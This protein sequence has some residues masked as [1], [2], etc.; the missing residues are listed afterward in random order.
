MRND[1]FVCYRNGW[2]TSLDYYTSGHRV[3]PLYMILI[4]LDIPLH[5]LLLHTRPDLELGSRLGLDLFERRTGYQLDQGHL[6]SLSIDLEHGL[7][8]HSNKVTLVPGAHSYLLSLSSTYE[9]GDDHAHA[10]RP[11]QG[12]R[13]RVQNLGPSLLVTVICYDN[14]LGLIGR[15]YQVHRAAH[16]L[17]QFAWNDPVGQVPRC[18]DFHGL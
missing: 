3:V 2:S 11:G 10:S 8:R 14:D 17:D 1:V 5:L 12:Q 7:Q 16:S 4:H 13:T 9:L 18:A 6:S 15:R